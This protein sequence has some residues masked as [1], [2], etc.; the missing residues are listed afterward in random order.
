MKLGLTAAAFAAALLAGAAGG[1]FWWHGD[2][3]APPVPVGPVVEDQLP[4]PPFPPRLGD[5]SGYVKCMSMIADDPEGAEAIAASLPPTLGGEAATHCHALASIAAGDPEAGARQLE[6]L[7]RGGKVDGMS[8]AVLLGQAAEARMM[9][10]Q[11]EGALLDATE[12]IS[13]APD[14]AD[15]L[16]GR[17]NALDALERDDEAIE[18]L[19]RA[20]RRDPA[21]GDALVSRASLLRRHDRLADARADIDRAIVIDPEDVDALLERGILRQLN[22]D[23][24][25]A[26]QD[27]MRLRQIDPNSDAAELAAQNLTLLDSGPGPK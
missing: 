4:I 1:W 5:D 2:Q 13:F 7:A 10:E 11:P 24:E 18:D 12:A 27:W 16:I 6:D 14:D 20:L 21:R 19:S 22:G 26:R 3:Q 8:R 17:A 15:L 23:P 25:G 9:A